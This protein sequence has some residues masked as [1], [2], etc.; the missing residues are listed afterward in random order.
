MQTK[1]VCARKDNKEFKGAQPD[2]V[3]GLGCGVSLMS[4]SSALTP[5]PLSAPPSVGRG[6]SITALPC[7]PINVYSHLSSPID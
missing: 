1:E 6:N 5:H 3:G 4:L 7:W 2:E